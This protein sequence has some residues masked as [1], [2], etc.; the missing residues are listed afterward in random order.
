MLKEV[1][2]KPNNH[3]E[4]SNGD[5]AARTPSFAGAE[6]GPFLASEPLLCPAAAIILP[7][8]NE[9]MLPLLQLRRDLLAGIIAGVVEDPEL[10]WCLWNSKVCK[11][12]G[13]QYLF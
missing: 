10:P 13:I 6:A 5:W 9:W 4:R 11:V 8:A 7:P 3:D 1:V 2:S 12:E